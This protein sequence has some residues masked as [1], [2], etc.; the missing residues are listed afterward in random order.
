MPLPQ[1]GSVTLKG[2]TFA[3]NSADI[4]VDSHAVL[5]SLA[6]GLKQHPRLKVQIQGYTD[7]KGSARYNLKLSQRRADAVR[8]YLIDQGVGSGQL[9]ARGFG[10]SDPVASNSTE[11][12]RA[13]N[14]RV[15]VFVVS[16]PNDVPTKGQGTTQPP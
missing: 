6:S 1:R 16:N 4:T 14:R 7:S 8:E 9:T 5:D 10:K 2:V 3:F 13:M 11:A 12:G 15:V